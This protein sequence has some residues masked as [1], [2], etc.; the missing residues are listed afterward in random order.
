MAEC[1]FPE[2]ELDDDE[3][4]LLVTLELTDTIQKAKPKP[5]PKKSAP[6]KTVKKTGKK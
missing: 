2:K 3:V 1:Q 5:A 4:E 6:K